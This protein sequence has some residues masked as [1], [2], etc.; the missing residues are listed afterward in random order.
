MTV[1]C[2]SF[3]AKGAGKLEAVALLNRLLS[4]KDQV[5]RCCFSPLSLPPPPP[6]HTFKTQRKPVNPLNYSVFLWSLC[7]QLL[8]VFP[9]QTG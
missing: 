8:S 7:H 4:A 3:Q 1:T 6:H 5:S 9:G 2:S